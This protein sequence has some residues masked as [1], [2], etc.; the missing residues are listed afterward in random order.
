MCERLHQFRH[1][2]GLLSRAHQDF[3]DEALGR[4]GDK[5]RN[6]RGDIVR[7][8]LLF[9]ILARCDASAGVVVEVR[10]DG[11]WSY[12]ADADIVLA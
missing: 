12:S 2:S 7:L 1:D 6:D 11:A 3:A 10:I 8:Q 4:L 9:R 5:C